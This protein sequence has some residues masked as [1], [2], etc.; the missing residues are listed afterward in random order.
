MKKLTISLVVFGL[1]VTGIS[2]S[3]IYSH[4]QSTPL[5]QS[6]LPTIEDLIKKV[7]ENVEKIQ[8]LRADVKEIEQEMNISKTEFS[9]KKVLRTTEYTFLFKKPD[10][11]KIIPKVKQGAPKTKEELEK[12]FIQHPEW[13]GKEKAEY[14][15]NEYLPQVADLI[16][17]GQAEYY[18]DRGTKK[19]TDQMPFGGPY[20]GET[21]TGLLEPRKLH[22]V[23]NQFRKLLEPYMMQNALT[24]RKDDKNPDIFIIEGRFTPHNVNPAQTS[25]YGWDW[26]TWEPVGDDKLEVKIDYK[27]GVLLQAGWY[28]GDSFQYVDNYVWVPFKVSA[29]RLIKTKDGTTK[30]IMNIKEFSNVFLNHNVA[31]EEFSFE[32]TKKY[33]IQRYRIKLLYEK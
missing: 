29:L 3:L 20:R 8:D 10:M 9:V 1:L 33:D 27:K 18:V 2:I 13:T 19:L 17:I 6:S 15:G 30:Y 25:P 32:N 4:A 21:W 26:E 16:S 11:I 14:Y 28:V 31:D 22:L 24:V 5:S 23:H 7:E 12:V